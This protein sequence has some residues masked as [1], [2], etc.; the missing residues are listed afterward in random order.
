LKKAHARRGI[1][2]CKF[3]GEKYKHWNL[4]FESR[5]PEFDIEEFEYDEGASGLDLDL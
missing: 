4:R 2:S 1:L 5:G 3:A